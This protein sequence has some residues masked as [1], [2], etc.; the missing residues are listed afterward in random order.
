MPGLLVVLAALQARLFLG[1]VLGF[2]GQESWK[3]TVARASGCAWSCEVPIQHKVQ[4]LRGRGG[5]DWTDGE[6]HVTHDQGKTPCPQP[7]W[8]VGPPSERSFGAN[9]SKTVS[10]ESATGLQEEHLFGS[11][12]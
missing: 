5:A 9:S 1:L 12:V 8:Q 7:F 3:S 11:A 2:K 6:G 4:Q 10:F